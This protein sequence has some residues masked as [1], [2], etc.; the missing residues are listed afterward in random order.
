M[1]ASLQ[2]TTASGHSSATNTPRPKLRGGVSSSHPALEVGT[3]GSTRGRLW[4]TNP[5][6]DG[7]YE[8]PYDYKE[9]N[10]FTPAM[11]TVIS[12]AL[13]ELGSDIGIIRFREKRSRDT[14]WIRIQSDTDKCQATVGRS[15]SAQDGQLLNLGIGGFPNR[16]T[17]VSNSIVQHEM[18]HALG[19][20]HEQS[21]PDRDRFVRIH[22]QHIVPGSLYNFDI[23]S[24]IESYGTPYDYYSVMHY[25]KYAFT[26][27]DF[28]TISTI[29][30][31]FTDII[32]SGEK[33]SDMDIVQSRLM[34]QCASGPRSYQ[35]YLAQPCT[36]DCKCAI[37]MS[38][39]AGNDDACHGDAVCS[40][41]NTCVDGSDQY[42]RRRLFSPSPNRHALRFRRQRSLV[43]GITLTPQPAVSAPSCCD[44]LSDWFSVLSIN[45]DNALEGWGVSECYH[46]PASANR[47][48]CG[49]GCQVPIVLRSMAILQNCAA[50][51]IRVD[52]DEV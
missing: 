30:T 24:Q 26:R 18:M 10:G 43:C 21:R 39:C 41:S 16:N 3:R 27:N 29:D 11:R 31:R 50:H 23:S 25:P 42:H 32:G 22:S 2:T 49:S 28:D 7:I 34:Y 9:P 15:A 36:S 8:V 35:D 38:G 45:I 37:G 47:S 20:L 48:E 12:N 1:G 5:G 17:C 13:A 40:A 14:E 44:V 52:I 6:S 51:G 19:F 46:W 33:A 4:N